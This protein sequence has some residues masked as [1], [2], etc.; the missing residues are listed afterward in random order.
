M[1]AHAILPSHHTPEGPGPV[2]R[3][4]R[5][6][7]RGTRA[8]PVPDRSRP[9]W[10]VPAC[11]GFVLFL[12]TT[13]LAHENGFSEL[14]G[15]LLGLATAAVATGIGYLLVRDRNAMI[16]EVRAAAYG[17]LAGSTLGFLHSVAGGS[18]L[19][20]LGIGLGFAVL[21]GLTSYYLFHW[22]ERHVRR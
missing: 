13:F 10:A 18:W 7:V 12:Y 5:L 15:W 14:G 2:P 17:A 9:A 22:N 16:T 20:S 19:R 3:S 11:L 6:P 1:P 4:A 21:V 8:G